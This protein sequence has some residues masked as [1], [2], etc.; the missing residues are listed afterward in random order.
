MFDL[1]PFRREKENT[2]VDIFNRPFDDLFRR[3]ISDFWTEPTQRSTRS[4]MPTVDISET[5]TDYVLKAE[6]PGMDAEDLDVNF[7]GDVLTI[8]GEKKSEKEERDHHYHRVERS[9][10]SFCRSFTLPHYTKAEEMEAIYK[11]GILVI[12][13]PKEEVTKHKSIPV[14]IN[15]E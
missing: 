11:N 9:Y 8:K 12:T 6:I 15:T 1:V 3:F 13:I 4:F 7:S 10:G 14:K 5:D 2:A